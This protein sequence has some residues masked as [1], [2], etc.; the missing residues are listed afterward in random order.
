MKMVKKEM[1][2]QVCDG[3]MYVDTR[4]TPTRRMADA[5]DEL[6]ADPILFCVQ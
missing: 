5:R 1:N 6:K 4:I 2:F 3:I